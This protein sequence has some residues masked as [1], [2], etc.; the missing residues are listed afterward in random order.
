MTINLKSYP[1]YRDP[2]VPWLGEVPEHWEVRKIGQVSR[3]FNGSTPSRLQS[4]Y[5]RAG[6]IPWLS[7]GK[8]NDYIVETPSELVT[9][10][11]LRECSISLV[12]KCSVIIGLIG[13]GKTR[14]M[15]ALLAIEACINQNLAAI[16]PRRNLDGRFLH[17]LLTAYYKEIREIG[18]GGNQEALN[19]DIVSRLR[20]PLPP[21]EEQVIIA[22][23]LTT[24]VS[25]FTHMIQRI[26][27]IIPLLQEFRIRIITDVITG[28]LDVR[29]AAARMPVEVEEAEPLDESEVLTEAEEVMADDLDSAF[30][31][32]EA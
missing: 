21:L 14:G 1:A 10:R 17:Y 30:E 29:E 27:Q 28:K 20:F 12:P 2:G 18:R 8:V 3:V 13:Q 16:V 32:V 11:A 19:C 24:S 4:A 22:E 9:E 5:W 31:E 15:S 26:K 25:H 6:T 23:R 7:S